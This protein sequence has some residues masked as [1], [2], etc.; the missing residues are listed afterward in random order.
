MN[1]VQKLEEQ[2]LDCWR[3]VDDLKVLFHADDIR[4]LTPD[5]RSNIVLG[6]FSLYQVKFE[7]LFSTFENHTKEFYDMKMSTE[8]ARQDAAFF[9]G[10]LKEIAEKE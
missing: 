4:E 9:K 5:E 3:V 8:L 2:I 6:L 10:K 7:T 1:T